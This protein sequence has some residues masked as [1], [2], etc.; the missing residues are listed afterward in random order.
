MT[1]LVEKS[2]CAGVLPIVQGDV[3]IAEETPGALTSVAPY[4][5][6]EVALSEAMETAHGIGFPA[7]GRSTGKV[8]GR[9]I[10]FGRGTAL[11][12]G[13]TPEATLREHAAMVD[14]SDAWATVRVEGVGARDV[15]A[16]LTPLDLRPAAFKQGYSARTELGHMQASITRTGP[17]SYLVMVFRSLAQTLAHDLGEAALVVAARSGLGQAGR[18]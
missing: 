3:R 9:A 15:L 2:P 11:L 10:F 1:K 16:R 8:G 5:G 17:Q 13:P 18:S 14:L 4:R 7:P 12:M 6:R